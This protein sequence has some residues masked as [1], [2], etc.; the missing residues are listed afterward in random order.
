MGKISIKDIAKKAGVC[1]GTVSRVINNLDRVHPE[2]R[3][4][5]L[6]L[7]EETGYRPNS[8]GRAL[9][10]GRTQ[11]VLVVLHNIA[12]PYCAA[13]SKILGNQWHNLDFKMLLG[14]SNYDAEL[15]CEHL[16]RAHDGSV[17]GLIISPIPGRDNAATFREMIKSGF[18]F[19]TIDNRIE[20]VKTNCVKYD[21][22][23]AASIAVEYLAQKGHRHISFVHTR[24]D[25]QTVKDRLVG[26]RET[27]RRLKLPLEK[28]LQTPISRVLAEIT[29][30]MRRK[31]APTAMV[32]ENEIT[33]MVCMNTLLQAGFKIPQDVAIIAIG[34]TL[35]DHF[36]PV[37]MTTVSL[38]HDLMCRK[39]VEILK[40]LIDNPSSRKQRLTQEI[41]QPELIIRTSA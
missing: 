6:K 31:P 19:V 13:L 5:I 9:V 39:A 34:D 27:L 35:P 1:I 33:A 3:E 41:I 24:P 30:A 22:Y 32:A 36:T 40:G 37:P 38:R 17:D 25:F 20:G 8:A 28:E 23:L 7:I 14:D 29:E 4:K 11:N 18:P 16:A 21:D 10:S 12:D 26:Y 2:T 15:E